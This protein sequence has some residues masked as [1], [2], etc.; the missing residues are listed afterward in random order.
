LSTLYSSLKFLRFTDRLDAIRDRQLVAPVHIRIKPMNYCNHDCWYC[1]YRMSSLQLGEDMDVKDKIPEDKMFEIVDDIIDMGVPAVTFSGG[2]EPLIYKPLPEVIRRL[3][4]GGVRV[5][6]LSNGANLRGA[7]ADAFAEHATWVRIS[8]EGWDGPSYAKARGIKEDAFGR[9]IENMRDFVARG[10]TCVLGI[11]LIVD[12]ENHTHIYELSRLLKDVGVNHVKLSAVITSN[13]GKENNAYHHK[14]MPRVNEEVERVK[15]L[16]DETFTVLDHY[17]T[18][19]ERFERQYSICPN[20][21]FNPVIGGDSIVYT[22]HDKA[23]NK[24]GILGSI[25]DRSFKEFWFSEENRE[26][27]FAINPSIDCPHH[28]ADHRKN[29]AMLE[30]LDVDPD[31]GVFV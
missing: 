13:D 31:H 24:G 27:V 22:C 17:H 5:G 2:G 3:A 29:L 20:I 23:F 15:T 26:R 18:L 14:L 12:A 8:M 21:Q 30:Y 6:S 28:C 25:K 10:S 4:A 19:D 7:V 1:A 9:L 11:S 16:A